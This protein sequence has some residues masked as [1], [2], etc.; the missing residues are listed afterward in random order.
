MGSGAGGPYS[1]TAGGSQPFAELYYVIKKML[2]L[3]K[4]NNSLYTKTNGYFKNPTAIELTN[5]IRGNTIVVD[6]K[7]IE[8]W[9]TYVVSQSGQFI[10]GI[11]KNPLTAG[12]RAPH[13]T[14]VGGK[15]PAVKAA[16]M[17]F[18]RRGKI[19]CVNNQSGHYRPNIKSMPN[20]EEILDKLFLTH[21]EV[22][23]A[24]SKWRQGL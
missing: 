16:G 4:A 2:T 1:G 9:L 8:G 6:G 5:A 3:D 20:V 24:T 15:N 14:L 11:R 22:F 12:G 17:I 10:I 23:H 19:V 18:F 21:P 7:R 13:P